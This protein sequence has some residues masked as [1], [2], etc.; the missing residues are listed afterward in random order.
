MNFESCLL[1]LVCLTAQK[2]LGALGAGER[3]ATHILCK[4]DQH[5]PLFLCTERRIRCCYNQ[6][7]SLVLTGT[8]KKCCHYAANVIYDPDTHLCNGTEV[9]Q[10]MPFLMPCGPNKVYHLGKETCRETLSGYIVEAKN[11]QKIDSILCV[12]GELNCCRGY[13]IPSSHLCYHG[14]PIEKRNPY[15]DDGCGEPAITYNTKTHGCVNKTVIPYPPDQKEICGNEFYNSTRDTCCVGVLYRGYSHGYICC[16]VAL[17]KQKQNYIC[18]G[19]LY[20]QKPTRRKAHE[21]QNIYPYFVLVK[22]GRKCRYKGTLVVPETDPMR[23]GFERIQENFVVIFK[24]RNKCIRLQPK[25]LYTI[26]VSKPVH[27]SEMS[28][29]LGGNKYDVHKLS[30]KMTKRMRKLINSDP[31]HRPKRYTG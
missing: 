3:C 27:S 23:A 6:D 28:M 30:E 11:V 21:Q 16:G 22:N 10:K 31:K 25:T 13:L 4:D 20:E 14:K 18:K 9:I 24:Q 7:E 2:V 26:V 15:D 19:K 5:G 1:F 17:H 8:D 29:V 12:I